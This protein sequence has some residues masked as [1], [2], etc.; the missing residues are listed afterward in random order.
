VD[1]KLFVIK[2]ADASAE[3]DFTSLRFD[4]QRPADKSRLEEVPHAP[5]KLVVGGRFGRGSDRIAGDDHIQ[6]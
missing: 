2:T 1:Q 4:R 5:R 6:P 3:G